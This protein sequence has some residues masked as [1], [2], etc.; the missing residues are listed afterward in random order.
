[1]KSSKEIAELFNTTKDWEVIGTDTQYKILEFDDEV[2][3]LFYGSNSKPDWKIN[4]S[5]FKKPYRNMPITYYVHKGFLGEWKKINDFFL[6]TIKSIDKP[7]TISG[8]SYGGAI[9]TLCLED[10]GFK[11]PEKKHTLFLVT[12]G[13]PRIIG[14]YN[15]RK[16]RKRWKNSIIYANNNDLVTKI[17]FW[18]LGYRHVKKTRDLGEKFHFFKLFKPQTYH[19]IDTYIEELEK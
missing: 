5:F 7:I 1:M 16:I 13:S 2:I 12:F 11:Y 3:I 19:T 4:F 6:D 15:Y 14:F 17:P 10:L 9:A 18:F 8:H